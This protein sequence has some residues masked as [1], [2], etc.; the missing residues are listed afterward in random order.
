MILPSVQ[1]M[2]YQ[3]YFPSPALAG[4]VR[5]YWSLEGHELPGSQ[6]RVFP[7]GCMEL[8]F[9]YGDLFTKYHYDGTSGYQPRSFI[10]GQLTRF[11]EI[12]GNGTVGIFSIRF[13]PHGLKPFISTDAQD[14]NDAAA[15]ITEI[16]GAAGRELEDRIL[17]AK[18]SEERIQI[19]ERFL[20]QQLRPAAADDRISHC[21]TAI[22]SRNGMININDLSLTL[23][24]SRRHLERQFVRATG[25]N[26]K[27]Y[28]RISRLQ[29]ILSLAGQKEY[30]SLTDLA[31]EGGFY[32]QA[33]FIRD[34]KAFTGL[35]PKQYF[36]EHLP[37]VKFFNME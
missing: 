36:S 15:G 26:P 22:D 24:T 10:H 1:F 2:N 3:L 17:N 13:H 33:H 25:L 19:M 12:G 18:G 34:F 20:L 32:D 11:I 5:C 14:L 7:D 30:T 21:I 6:Q 28:A 4:F 9:H 29:H 8:V 31:Y 37:L 27:Q 16:W 35:S 23:N